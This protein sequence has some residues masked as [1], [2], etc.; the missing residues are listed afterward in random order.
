MEMRETEESG[1]RNES[2]RKRIPILLTVLL[3]FFFFGS[4]LLSTLKSFN[5]NY[6]GF[7]HLQPHGIQRNAFLKANPNLS[8]N[9]LVFHRGGHD[10]KF[11][12]SVAFDPFLSTFSKKLIVYERMLDSPPLRFSRIGYPLLIHFF[13]AGN[14]E[15]FPKTMMWLVLLS[16]CF[17]IF[18]LA[19]ILTHYDQSAFWAL[20]YLIIPGLTVSS[21]RV[22][23]ESISA[24]FLLAGVFFYLKQRFVVC[25]LFLSFAILIRESNM[26]VVLIASAWEAVLKNKSGA[27]LLMGSLL[28]FICWRLFLTYRLFPFFGWSTLFHSAQVLSFPFH[29]IGVLFHQI[30]IHQYP[31]KHASPAMFLAILLC[32]MFFVSVYLLVRR[33]DAITIL[34]FCY[35]LLAVS[36]DYDKTWT[37]FRNAERVTF[38]SFIFFIIACGP[39]KGSLR[40]P[41]LRAAL[42]FFFT[43]TLLYDLFFLSLKGSF[44]AGLILAGFF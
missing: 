12:Y 28:P 9:L 3:A 35:S 10:T 13:S 39:F 38:E 31:A 23:P 29:G 15:R 18:F 27:L 33:R 5:G 4:M 36:L 1:N 8:R 20:L 40:F 42:L 6:S 21:V 11:Y 24:A 41:I 17:S 7:I 25:A 43:M 22:L 30:A 14:P 26:I 16:H 19:K 34:F 2:I 44:H 32:L 37:G